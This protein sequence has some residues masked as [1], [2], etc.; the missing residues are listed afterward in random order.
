MNNKKVAPR[1]KLST[2]LDS[3]TTELSATDK[4]QEKKQRATMLGA[5]TNYTKSRFQLGQALAAYKQA[6]KMERI[7]LPASEAIAKH[8]HISPRTL[9]RIV[10]DYQRLSGVSETLLL[11]MEAEG[12]DPAKP[13]NA[14]LLEQV[15][16]VLGDDPT[17]EEAQAVVRHTAAS[18]QKQQK[19]KDTISEDDRI[20]WGLRQAVRKWLGNITD[21]GHKCELLQ[22]VISGESF[23]VWG[24]TKPWTFVVHPDFARTLDSPPRQTQEMAA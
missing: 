4:E 3:I 11:A 22:E 8:L 2:M 16:E 7:W 23:E 10:S 18:A 6:C 5:L 9:F 14:P 17:P 13:K 21:I 24:D 20:V 19:S 12:L 1:Q 15:T